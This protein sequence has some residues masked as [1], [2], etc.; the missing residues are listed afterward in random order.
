MGS[1]HGP[2]PTTTLTLRPR[3]VLRPVAAGETNREIAAARGLTTITM[4]SFWQEVLQKLG[5]S[6]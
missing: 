5:A 2:E 3:E 4:K 1:T 6:E